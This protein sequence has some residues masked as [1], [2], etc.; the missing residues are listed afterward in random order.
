MK[1][2]NSNIQTPEKLQAPSF[3]TGRALLCFGVW[4]LGFLW[5]LELGASM[6]E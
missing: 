4:T 1:A 6:Y 5:S 2:P 3:N